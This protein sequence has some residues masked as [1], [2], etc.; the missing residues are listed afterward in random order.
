V[1]VIRAEPLPD[2]IQ[3]DGREFNRGDGSCSST[4]LF[5]A[6]PSFEIPV[7]LGNDILVFADD[8]GPDV[9]TVL[10]AEVEPECYVSYGLSGGP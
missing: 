2:R 10:Y 7:L 5:G 6:K 8:T 3:H 1:L 9:T 4:R